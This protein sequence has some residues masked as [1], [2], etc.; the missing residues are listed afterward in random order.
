MFTRNF[1]KKK[2]KVDV[3]TCKFKRYKYIH[4]EK[5]KYKKIQVDEIFNTRAMSVL[6]LYKD[7]KVHQLL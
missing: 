3:D 5:M 6:V 7:H 2:I 1:T 4:E